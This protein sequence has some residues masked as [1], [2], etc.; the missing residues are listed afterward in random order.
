MPDVDNLFR[1]YVAEH[2]SGG[3]ADPASY[4]GRLEGPDRAE[5]EALIDAYLARAPGR[6]WD[7]AA[8]EGSPAQRVSEAIA[9]KW[10]D[11]E[12]ASEPSAWPELLPTLRDRARLTR[13][14]LVERLAQTLGVAGRERRVAA[15]YHQMETGA[16]PS[17]GVSNR[18]MNA[19]AEL[20]GES[21]ERLR[22]AGSMLPESGDTREIVTKLAFARRASRD[23]AFDGREEPTAPAAAP[24]PAGQAAAEEPGEELDLVDELFTGGP[25]AGN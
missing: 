25:D 1:D 23:P 5:L 11:W 9:T 6:E 19:L 21:T 12:L 22:T 20:L 2:R 17:E 7:A 10:D 13:K 16:L 8:F 15:Y 4:L 18:V 14:R 24:A 3:R